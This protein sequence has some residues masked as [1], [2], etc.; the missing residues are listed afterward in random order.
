MKNPRERSLIQRQ[1]TIQRDRDIKR[2]RQTENAERQREKR[3]WSNPNIT[4]LKFEQHNDIT[5]DI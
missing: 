3:E 4:E 1:R 5:R 2:Q